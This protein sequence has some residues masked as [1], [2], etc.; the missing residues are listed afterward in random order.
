V[1]GSPQAARSSVFA[2]DVVSALFLRDIATLTNDFRRLL[3]NALPEF[4]AASFALVFLCASSL[5]LLRLTRWPLANIMLLMV[6][7]R[8]YFL[9]YHV[10]ATRLAPAVS[11]AVTDPLLVRL[12]PS[13][14]FIVLGIILLL[15]DILFIPANRWVEDQ[16]V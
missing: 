9:L 1:S 15:V 6:A 10:L 12:F 4:F 13:A 8:G 7:V 5:A 2:P 11:G 16:P 3:E 14:S